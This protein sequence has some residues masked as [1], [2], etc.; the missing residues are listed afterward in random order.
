MT[1]FDNINSIDA[2]DEEVFFDQDSMEEMQETGISEE[3]FDEN[4]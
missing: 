2:D 3:D 1:D 4:E